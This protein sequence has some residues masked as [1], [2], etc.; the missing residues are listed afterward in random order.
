MKNEHSNRKPP[1]VKNYPILTIS[2]VVLLILVLIS[3]VSRSK[4]PNT[5]SE[6]LAIPDPSTVSKMNASDIA[7]LLAQ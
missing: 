4:N 1:I 2:L 7:A 6:A 5:S 3:L